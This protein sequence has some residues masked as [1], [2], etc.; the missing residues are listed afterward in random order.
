M[1]YTF[2]KTIAGNFDEV[3]ALVIETLKEEKFGV[4]TEINVQATMKEKLDKDM[5]RYE[6]LGACNPG[7]AFKAISADEDM[8]AFLPC[9]VTLSEKVAGE[10]KVSIVNPIPMISMNDNKEIKEFANEVSVALKKV[11]DKL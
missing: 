8:G 6:I 9:N 1:S 11:H 7:Y 3:K 5:H 10:I 4:I 2:N